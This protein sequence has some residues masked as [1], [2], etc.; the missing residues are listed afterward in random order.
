[1]WSRPVQP[2]RPRR[3]PRWA[4]LL[5][6]ASLLAAACGGDSGVTQ[7]ASEPLDDAG[8]PTVT[9]D[10]D[11]SPDS[12]SGGPAV[13]DDPVGPDGTE[14]PPTR[15]PGDPTDPEDPDSPGGPDDP[16]EAG[17]PDAASGAGDLPDPAERD[18][19]RF[20]PDPLEW[21]PM[22]NGAEATMLAVP[23]D[24][25]EPDGDTMDLF[26]ARRPADDPDSR[27]GSLLVNPG[28]PGFGGTV[29]A[30]FADQVY[31]DELLRRFDI[32][33][34]DPRG[35]GE[36]EPAV[37]CIDDWDEYVGALDS[38]DDPE[39][40]SLELAQQFAAE[41][42]R[43]SDGI[44]QH[45]GTN[46]SAR[47]MDVIRRALGEDT[48]SYFGFSYG[49][50]LGATWATLFPDT[51]RA[52]VL[53]GASDP[54]A[55]RLESSLQQLAGFEASLGTFLER[56]GDA[57]SCP[58]HGGGDAGA[59]FDQLMAELDDDPIPSRPGRPDVG[60]SI[61][62]TAV[63]QA[64][65]SEETWP[66]LERALGDA[67]AGDGSGLLEL[68][69]RYYQREPGGTYGDELE[70]FQVISCAD[71]PDRPTPDELAEEVELFA[72]VA[73]RL[74]PADAEVS[75]FCTFMPP[76]LDPRV[77]VTADGAG[78]VVV[79]GTTG[80]PATPFESTR[81]MAEALDDGRFV[82]VE[83]DQHTGYGVNSCV[84]E[85]VNRYLVDLDAPADG[86]ECE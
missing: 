60:R 41:C 46:N 15:R 29:F 64:M 33:G 49:S 81:A 39:T 77:T 58:L 2:I 30:L 62:T 20:E 48:I 1:M 10:P 78:P 59:E 72:E 17:E 34:W 57:P 27:I 56:C 18:P 9:A 23:I 54:E 11:P 50:A 13:D 6:G 68:Y 14:P 75:Y 53:D 63:I 40:E 66:R 37:D 85:L 42:G 8:S 5:A 79:I 19:R 16:V 51:V 80:D 25:T 12:G 83:A 44:V 47:D 84:V 38:S 21:E 3:A 55:E 7:G 45:V 22:G 70:A 73:P 61:A 71:R 52:A 67:V 32:V 28:G 76:A 36:S 43:R 86:T 4:A 26:V 82:I 74:A 35:T 69:D 24:Y 31:D 65:Y